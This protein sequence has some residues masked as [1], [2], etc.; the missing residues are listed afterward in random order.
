ME[1]MPGFEKSL[2]KITSA[3]ALDALREILVE[4]SVRRG[5]AADAVCGVVPELY[6]EPANEAELARVLE[7]ANRAEML[8]TPRGSGTKMDWGPAAQAIDLM[9]SSAKFDRIL[10]YAPGD[11]TVTVGSGVTI[12]QIQSALAEHRQRLA[13]DPLWPER[14]TVGG[15]I[16]TNDSG[17][18]RLRYGSIR[19]LII[20]ITVVLGDGTIATSGG[21]VVK[22][23]AGYDLP[24]LMSGAHGT[25]GIITRAVFR[26]HPLPE[27][28]NTLSFRFLNREQAN[29][30]MLAIADSVMVPTGLQMRTGA[31]GDVAVDVRID[32]IAAGIAA[33]TETL[34]KLAAAAHATETDS[35]EADPWQARQQLWSSGA[36]AICKLSTL[37][38]QL[39]AT[40]EFIREALSD[41]ADWTLLMHSTGLA[42][43]QLNSTDCAR[44]AAFIASMRGF[45]AP[46][47]G[48]AV[49][50]KAPIILRQQVDLWGPAG[51]ALPLMK[52]IK[53]QFDPRGILNRGRFVG[54]I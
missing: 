25:L 17:A 37:P 26:L 11:M 14:T 23:V 9:V 53:E 48:T 46:V 24:K 34:R 40:A 33:Q 4:G 7:Y 45:L 6:A 12:A 50:L 10:E 38:T 16:A 30:F 8:V 31:A 39:S 42:W 2:A 27:Q 19:D 28:S 13:L 51:S 20:G 32:G 21:K 49:V 22:N 52:R 1:A 15:V 36:G 41:N 5:V 54:G 44:I 47:G 3:Q 18:L 35:S 43:L 29:E